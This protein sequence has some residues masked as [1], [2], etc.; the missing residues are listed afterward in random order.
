[1][2]LI[3]IPPIKSHE[4]ASFFACIQSAWRFRG[5]GKK[6]TRLQLQQLAGMA[7]W[8]ELPLCDKSLQ[9]FL[10]LGADVAQ[11]FLLG[12]PASD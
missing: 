6:S 1:M 4:T 12:K 7:D 5:A 8:A 11:Y 2:V 10:K 3:P 9:S